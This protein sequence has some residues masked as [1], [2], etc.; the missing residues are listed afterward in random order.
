MV[1]ACEELATLAG[2]VGV[3]LTERDATEVRSRL[4][5]LAAILERICNP[6]TPDDPA[7][8]DLPTERTPIVDV[9]V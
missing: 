7:P 5:K 4:L 9:G 2:A 6:G 8:A 1:Y 3:G